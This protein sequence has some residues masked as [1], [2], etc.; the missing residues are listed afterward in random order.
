MKTNGRNAFKKY[1]NS[2]FIF[3]SF[4]ML[5]KNFQFFKKLAFIKK[6]KKVLKDE[7]EP[8]SE[9]PK[10]ASVTMV[11]NAVVETSLVKTNSHSLINGGQKTK[12]PTVPKK[13][14]TLRAKSKPKNIGSNE[15]AGDYVNLIK[16]FLFS[17]NSILTK[18]FLVLDINGTDRKGSLWFS[19]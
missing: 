14:Y 19:F 13:S 18:L 1:F 9:I 16:S 2:L 8:Q 7:E 6:T 17:R 10:S 11:N 5:K 4:K 12:S 3:K 15:S